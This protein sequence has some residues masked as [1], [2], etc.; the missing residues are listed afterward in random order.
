[1]RNKFILLL[2]IIGL[3]ALSSC[4]SKKWV[5]VDESVDVQAIMRDKMPEL[6]TRYTNGKITIS[7][8]EQRVDDKGEVKY[9]VT[10]KNKNSNDDD[11]Y[12]WP[13]IYIPGMMD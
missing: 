10:Y 12:L 7:K 1:M 13:T 8:V 2:S 5:K 3:F 11:L 9:R 4:A 6:Y